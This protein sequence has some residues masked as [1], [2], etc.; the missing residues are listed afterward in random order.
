M[1][2]APEMEGFEATLTAVP[3]T[4]IATTSERTRE[5]VSFNNGNAMEFM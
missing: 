1:S 4:Q 3:P 2:T 5:S